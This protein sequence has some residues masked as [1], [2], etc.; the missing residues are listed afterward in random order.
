M[1]EIAK[2][3]ADYDVT[4]TVERDLRLDHFLKRRRT[5]SMISLFSSHIYI[6]LKK[7]KLMRKAL[8]NKFITHINNL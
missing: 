7:G 1:N 8:D 6:P 3:A 5:F 4:S 2:F